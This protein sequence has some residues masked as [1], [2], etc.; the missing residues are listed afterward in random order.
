MRNTAQSASAGDTPPA[1]RLC[2]ES[3]GSADVL[4]DGGWWPCSYDPVA[5]LRQLVLA[6]DDRHRPIARVLLG[7]AD[8]GNVRPRMLS[9]AGPVATRIIRLRWFEAMP[10]GLLIA[11][12]SD[13]R[14]TNLLTVPPYTDTKSAWAAMELAAHPDNELHTPDILRALAS[15]GPSV[16][17]W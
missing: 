11:I 4:L 10:A 15:I 14:R 13:G 8:W 9:I 12:C 2:L 16:R 5:E 17:T 6:I 7:T 1:A 3:T